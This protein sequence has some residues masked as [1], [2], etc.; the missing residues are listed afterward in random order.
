MPPK[1]PQDLLGSLSGTLAREL[2]HLLS[3]VIKR[4][5]FA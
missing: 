2:T 5:M 3:D 4:A 1:R